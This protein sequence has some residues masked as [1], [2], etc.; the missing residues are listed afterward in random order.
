MENFQLRELVEMYE[1]EQRV[2]EVIWFYRL[3]EQIKPKV[4]LEIG[5]KKCGNMKVLS[6]LLGNDGLI[7]GIDYYAH[8][9]QEEYE[10]Y[11]QWAVAADCDVKHIIGNS[12]DPEIQSKLKEILGNRSIDVLFIDG[13]HS[14]EGML[15]DYKDYSPLVNKG[16]II[17]IHDIYY[18]EKVAKA[19]EDLPVNN[20]LI[21]ER[22]QSSIG[23]GVTYKE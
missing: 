23:I 5:N 21:S 10:T 14:Y 22:N 1:A 18:L 9:K 17:A 7:V 12:H 16:G 11:L 20:R 4:I 15:Q 8:V 19:W 3:C 2:D 13:D 6:T